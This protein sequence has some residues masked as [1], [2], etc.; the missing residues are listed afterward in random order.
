MSAA[1]GIEKPARTVKPAQTV[2]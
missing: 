1:T 2:V